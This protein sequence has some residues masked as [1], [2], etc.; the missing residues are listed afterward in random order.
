MRSI[1]WTPVLA[2]LLLATGTQ[3]IEASPTGDPVEEIRASYKAAKRD[4]S[5]TVE[6]HLGW[7]DQL[8]VLADD[9]AG[10][11]AGY[12]ALTAIL[13]ISRG[14]RS[15]EITDAVEFVPGMLIEGY[16]GDF[17]KM[18]KLV[19]RGSLD[20][21]L[22]TSLLEQTPNDRVK[23]VCYVSQLGS[24]MEGA[25]R[26]PMKDANVERAL[27]AV[28][29]LNGPL[30]ELENSA[31]KPFR[32]AVAAQVFE[33]QNLRIGMVAPDIVAKDLDGVEFKL[34]DYRGKVVVLDFWGNW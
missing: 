3:M 19:S 28:E 33:L 17:D 32:E 2:G 5:L 20:D 12:E 26:G 14:S 24:A 27:A 4:K 8:F 13:E 15:R 23:A 29:H 7:I 22:L 10:K 31:G 9:G 6:Q 1:P 21:K 30:G 25:S 16:S 11:D 18:E 34:S